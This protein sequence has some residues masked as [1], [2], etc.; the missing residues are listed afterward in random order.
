MIILTHPLVMTFVARYSTICVHRF[1]Q[2]GSSIQPR[3]R[4]ET[5]RLSNRDKRHD[6]RP[7]N[8]TQKS[9]LQDRLDVASSIENAM[10]VDFG[11]FDRIDDAVGFAVYFAEFNDADFE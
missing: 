2:A 7:R 6:V 9:L 3:L 5:L 4:K 11:R 10:D 1:R 8:L